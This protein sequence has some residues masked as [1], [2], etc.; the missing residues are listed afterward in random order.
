MLSETILQRTL[1]VFS[2]LGLLIAGCG[3]ESEQSDC[4]F[5]EQQD[6]P[7]RVVCPDG[8]EF[9]LEDGVD[10]EDGADG[11]DGMDCTV[12]EPGDGTT[13][14]SCEDG[15]TTV[16]EDGEDGEDG[17]DGVHC[18][19]EDNDDGSYDLICDNGQELTYYDGEDGE[20]G[21]DGYECQI[22]L[23]SDGYLLSCDGGD[24]EILLPDDGD[25][26]GCVVN[27]NGDNTATIDC[28]DSPEVTFPLTIPEYDLEVFVAKFQVNDEG[29]AEAEAII[30]NAGN[31]DFE[32]ETV[33]IKF[34]YDE[35]VGDVPTGGFGDERDFYNDLLAPNETYVSQE[36]RSVGDSG[37]NKGWVVIQNTDTDD[38]YD[39][40]GPVEYSL[41]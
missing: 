40:Y 10:G 19:V 32:N 11:E 9:E 27:D 38:Y 8:E 4:R 24:T 22:A 5:Q 14:L 23:A 35:E 41:D 30:R 13:V 36:S 17:Q 20:D 37:T 21:E 28:P 34:Y 7:D 12:E 2:I 18:S 31:G 39:V 16:I 26:G 3:G 6:G 25:Q 15:T 1:V 33:W 29:D